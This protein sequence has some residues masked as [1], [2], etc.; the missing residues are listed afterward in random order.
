MRRYNTPSDASPVFQGHGVVI[1]V[2]I[3]YYYLTKWCKRANLIVR[4]GKCKTLGIKKNGRLSA[5]FKPCLRVN[6]ELILPV[7]MGDN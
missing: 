1:I 5:Q 6:I 2:I 3:I 7:K 4:V